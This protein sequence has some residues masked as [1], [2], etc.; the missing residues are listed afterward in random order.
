MRI[1]FV[2]T[3]TPHHDTGMGLGIAAIEERSLVAA[4]KSSAALSG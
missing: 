2:Y 1:G 3:P 4:G